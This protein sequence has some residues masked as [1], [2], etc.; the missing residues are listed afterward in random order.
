MG[1]RKAQYLE[2]AQVHTCTCAHTHTHTNT[3]TQTHHKHTCYLQPSTHL[4]V[5]LAGFPQ[6][7]DGPHDG[8]QDS[9]AADDVY[10]VKHITPREPVDNRGALLLRDHDGYVGKHLV[11]CVCMCVC[12]PAIRALLLCDHDSNVGR[13]LVRC[14]CTC[15]CMYVCVYVRVCVCTCVYVCV[16]IIILYVCVYMCVCVCACTGFL[17]S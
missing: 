2:H 8:E 13:H 3:H 14:V 10:Q 12:V 17:T 15:V 9:A 7:L 6:V 16:C 4:A 5:C 11:V 1:N